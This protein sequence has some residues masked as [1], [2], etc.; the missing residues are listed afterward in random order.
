MTNTNAHGKHLCI[1]WNVVRPVVKYTFAVAFSYEH[2]ATSAPSICHTAK[3]VE[4]DCWIKVQL[5]YRYLVELHIL[6][7]CQCSIMCCF[8]SCEC[9]FIFSFLFLILLL[10]IWICLPNQFITIVLIYLIRFEFLEK[11]SFLLNVLCFV[12]WHAACEFCDFFAV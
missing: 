10:F 7:T 5:Y 2:K 8:H 3:Q 12:S 4:S 1:L 11:F 6:C 9:Q